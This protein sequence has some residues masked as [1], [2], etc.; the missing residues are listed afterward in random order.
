MQE[1]ELQRAERRYEQAKA[2]LQALRNRE[3][4]RERKLDTRRK[5]ILGGALIDLA[6]RDDSARAMLERLM[7]NFAREQDRKVF[8]GW[9]PGRGG[10]DVVGDSRVVGANAQSGSR[11]AA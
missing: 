5:V 10:G 3:A 4:T 2:R 1:T 6:A 7:R 8:E 9:D 11:G